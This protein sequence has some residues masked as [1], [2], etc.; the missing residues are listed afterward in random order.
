[1]KFDFEKYPIK[2]EYYDWYIV[3][4]KYKRKIT[5]HPLDCEI[6]TKKHI[7]GTEMVNIQ[8]FELFEENIK[9][10]LEILSFDNLQKYSTML[11]EDKTEMG[12]RDGWCL[13]YKVT[14]KNKQSFS[15]V[16]K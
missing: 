9:R 3:P 5:I 1:M 15:G 16:T 13:Y 4:P 11:D 8:Y 6:I 12:Y 2:I 14:F 10:M 7:T